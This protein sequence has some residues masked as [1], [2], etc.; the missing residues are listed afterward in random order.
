MHGGVAWLRAGLALLLAAAVVA[1]LVCG[2]EPT[3][4]RTPEGVPGLPPPLLGVALIG[5]GAAAAAVD[6]YG[7][8]VDLRRSPAGPAL[9]TVPAARQAAGSADPA[10]AIVPTVRLGTEAKPVPIYSANWVRQRYRAGANVLVTEAGF[11]NAEVAITWVATGGS[12]AC[13]TAGRGA[14]VEPE[15]PPGLRSGNVL[16]PEATTEPM[17]C[18]DRYAARVLRRALTADR[19]WLARARPLRHDAP[20][21]AVRLYHRSLLVLRASTAR[22]GAVAA[23]AREGWAYVWPRDAGAAALAY[24]AAGYRPEARRVA[25]FLLGL[26]LEAAA[27]FDGKGEPVPG[28]EAQGDAAG[29][30]LAAAGAAGL[31]LS[32]PLAA[33]LRR[34]DWRDRADYQE[35]SPGAYLANAL[36][37]Q[38]AGGTKTSPHG[39]RSGH[40]PRSGWRLVGDPASGV[41]SA[42]AWAVRPFTRRAL[43]PAARR[44]LLRLLA[45]GGR[46]GIV[47]STDWPEAD[48]WTA[49]TAWS[50]WALAALA[51][52]DQWQRER[53]RADRRAALHLLA[54]LRR[55][56]TPAGDLPERVDATGGLPRSTTPL[57]WSHAFAILALRELWPARP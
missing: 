49:P 40:R 36:A 7:D 52:E 31:R 27:R 47:P 4:P 20:A 37:A 22:D 56:A 24:A 17:H 13:L 45:A 5:D 18:D 11:G 33:R 25:R 46:Y 35:K 32:P 23:G 12:L 55:A 10:A 48:P 6:S 29:W 21:W 38:S 44:S 3:D 34:Y 43:Y 30:A 14:T 41:D 9:L 2:G 57:T 19:S 1:V 28:R 50:A 15:T 53:A 54:D 26:D 39:R 8:V 42:A 51:R 16:A